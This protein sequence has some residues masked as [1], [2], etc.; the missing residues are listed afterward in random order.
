MVD[1]K[2]K[3]N[4]RDQFIRVLNE[5]DEMYKKVWDTQVLL[6]EWMKIS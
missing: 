3:M 4:L 1:R 6:V 5:Y 2:G